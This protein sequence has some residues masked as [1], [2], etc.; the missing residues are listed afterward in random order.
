MKSIN[1]DFARIAAS[2]FQ[3]E[4]FLLGI[5]GEEMSGYVSADT[6]TADD[7]RIGT[8]F[9]PEPLWLSLDLKDSHASIAPG[10]FQ[11]GLHER[12]DNSFTS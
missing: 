9:L 3:N 4:P 10:L 1:E 8:I 5:I 11:I 2:M 7:C 12:D 6:I